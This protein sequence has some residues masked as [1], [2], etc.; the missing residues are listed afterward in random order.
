[1]LVP[2]CQRSPGSNISGVRGARYAW[3]NSK[4]LQVALADAGI[5]YEHLPELAPTTELRHVQ[6]TEDARLGVG[7]RSR[8][9]LADEYVTRF[10]AERL[11]QVELAP[12]VESLPADGAVALLCVE[13]DPEACH[14]SLVAER[15]AQQFGFALEHLRPASL[16]A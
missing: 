13:R 6:Y 5:A 1:M 11:D 10:T 16:Q 15:I 8:S 4:R 2:Y 7:K 3:A 12:I 14:R 9:R